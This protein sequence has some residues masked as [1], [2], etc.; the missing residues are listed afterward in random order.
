MMVELIKCFKIQLI[1]C[2]KSVFGNFGSSN[3]ISAT[4]F[5]LLEN[6]WNS[7]GAKIDKGSKASL[8]PLDFELKQG[9]KSKL[10]HTKI[11]RFWI[12]IETFL[13]SLSLLKIE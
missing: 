2:S 10:S 11:E 6:V 3:K 9:L 4:S 7:S 12:K 8:A 5:A 1:R 13:A